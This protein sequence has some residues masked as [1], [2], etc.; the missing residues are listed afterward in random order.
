MTT[1]SAPAEAGTIQ[2]L[3]LAIARQVFSILLA[4]AVLALL[5]LALNQ[6]QFADDF[7]VGAS[8]VVYICI[9]LIVSIVG[10]IVFELFEIA[11]I[12]AQRARW[13]H[14]RKQLH[15]LAEKSPELLML[16]ELTQDMQKASERR[17]ARQSMLQNFIFYALGVATPILLAKAQ[18]L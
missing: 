16:F 7:A 3:V 14:F 17:S 9:G 5:L 2:R 12:K 10:V 4:L 1:A 11:R 6:G 15:A 13:A 8:Y 18:L